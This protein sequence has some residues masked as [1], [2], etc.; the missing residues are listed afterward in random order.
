MWIF[1]TNKSQCIC[2]HR[3]MQHT[4][5]PILTLYEEHLNFYNL[6][7]FLEM[8]FDQKLTWIPYVKQQRTRCLAKFSIF[9]VLNSHSFGLIRKNFFIYIIY[10]SALP[11]T[12]KVLYTIMPV[13]SLLKC[14]R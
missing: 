7:S 9:K 10:L 13:K 4:P 5:E 12:M 14:W 3:K 11:S 1:C 8:I 6:V 2:S